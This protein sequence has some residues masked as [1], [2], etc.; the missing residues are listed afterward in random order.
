MYTLGINAVYHDSAAALLKD[1]VVIA[2]AEDERF[3][4]VKHAKRPVP[5][6][7]WQLPFDAIDYCLKE[8]GIELADV[9]HVA[10]SYDP[11]LLSTMPSGSQPTIELPLEPGRKPMTNPSES[12]WDPLFL[13]YIVNAQ[14]QLARRRAASSAKALQERR[15]ARAR[16]EWHYVDHHLSHE[17]SAFLAAP[18]TDTA[19]LTMDGRGEGVTTS[20]G[21]FV[22]GE[23][24]RLKQVEL[25]HS[26]GLLY[27]AVTAYL[28]FLHSSDE[29]KVMALASYGK[30]LFVDQFREIVKYRHDGTYTV[31]A[32]RLV[33]RFGPPRERGGPLEQRH[34]DIAHSLQVVLE[35]TVLELARW[36]H[37]AD[38]SR[39]ISRWRAA[40]RSTA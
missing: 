38:G 5:F 24:T 17:A 34:F 2:A 14:A 16:F 15:T 37:A 19:V 27:E 1:G 39:L 11:R 28:G 12:P 20:L 21:Q 18:F 33:D 10:Y 26:L 8:A 3:T 6:S 23:Y 35:D 36:L 32:P 25:P 31:D 9:D 40:S 4:H 13:S 29:Y 22:D 30:P 7:T